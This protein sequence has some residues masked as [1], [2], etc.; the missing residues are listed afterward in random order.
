MRYWN[1]G[2][3][4]TSIQLSQTDFM[5][6][7]KWNRIFKLLVDLACIA[8]FTI[9]SA[10]WLFCLSRRTVFLFLFGSSRNCMQFIHPLGS[11]RVHFFVARTLP[12]S[13]VY[14]AKPSYKMHWLFSILFVAP[15]IFFL[16]YLVQFSFICLNCVP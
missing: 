4:I 9:F 5:N 3:N 2:S 10:F 16:L 7:S 14:I 6:P 8:S 12:H 15:F 11:G 1:A 13:A